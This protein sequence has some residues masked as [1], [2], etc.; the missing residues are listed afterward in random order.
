MPNLT[1]LEFVET[2]IFTKRFGACGL[3]DSLLQL[4][5]DLVEDPTR[6]PVIGGLRGARK[7]RVGDKR[8]GKGKSGSY[9]YI[10]LYLSH[11]NRVYLLFVFEKNEQD[12]LS[13]E[14]R[15]VIAKLCEI[16]RRECEP[17]P[18]KMAN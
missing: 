15:R 13:E 4:Q 16:L 8:G 14:Q 1:W 5:S 11:I 10:Y 9:R 6:W 17:W 2:S 7:G 18:P 12:N 3:H